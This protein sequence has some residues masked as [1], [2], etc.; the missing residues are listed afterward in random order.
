MEVPNEYTGNP[1]H[2]PQG[3]ESCTAE[4]R[5]GPADHHPAVDPV[6]GLPLD[7]GLRAILGERGG[8]YTCRSIYNCVEA[9][10][11]GIDI[12]KAINQVRQTL[13]FH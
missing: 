1:S 13:L 2:R 7:H 11:R 3:F 10:P 6:C 8:V 9:C 12:T 4:Q 5:S